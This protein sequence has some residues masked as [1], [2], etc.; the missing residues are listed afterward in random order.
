MSAAVR[1]VAVAAFLLA[2]PA[3]RAMAW[4][5]DGHEIVGRIAEDRLTPR[6]R[7]RINRIL[8]GKSIADYGIANGPDLMLRLGRRPETAKWH[9]VNIPVSPDDVASQFDE[10]RDGQGGDCVV[11]QINRYAELLRTTDD[12]KKQAEAVMFLTHLVGDIHQPL[13]CAKR[14]YGS[15]DNDRGGNAITV[16]L[17][18]AGQGRELPPEKLHAVWDTALIKRMLRASNLSPNAYADALNARIT[19]DDVAAWEK[20][21]SPA[22]WANE[23]IKIAAAVCY[24]DV[25]TTA[26]ADGAP[27]RLSQLYV[28]RAEP[29]INLQL[30]K[31]GVRLAQVLNRALADPVTTVPN[32]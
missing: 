21:A 6:A 24:K 10:A 18:A 31:A 4:G 8:E 5:Q 9:Y 11:D 16:L 20:S 19:P 23:G 15:S 29:V 7:Q 30:Q 27:V 2:L 17:P 3:S 12:P 25:P 14:P 32:R 22:D 13:H 28:S 1:C 26:P